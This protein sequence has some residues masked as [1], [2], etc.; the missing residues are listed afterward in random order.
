MTY[1][2]KDSCV[3]NYP[4]RQF[5]TL[6]RKL[7][8]EQFS[9]TGSASRSSSGDKYYQGLF[10]FT[11]L[12]PEFNLIL[13]VSVILSQARII[14]AEMLIPAP[15]TLELLVRAFPELSHEYCVGQIGQ[16]LR[17]SD[18][19]RVLGNY[20]A[21][22]KFPE[23]PRLISKLLA[24]A[25]KLAATIRRIGENKELANGCEMQNDIRIMGIRQDRIL[26]EEMKLID[27]K[28]K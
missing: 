21:Y 16:V 9:Q 27:D 28:Y 8:E 15:E 20:A 22:L 3:M 12:G 11:R 7:L 5:R 19:T 17:T 25:S 2:S 18:G 24:Q 23:G 13:W 26:I 6:R 10:L 14:F 4:S 1:K